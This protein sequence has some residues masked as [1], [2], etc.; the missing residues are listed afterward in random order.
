MKPLFKSLLLVA[1]MAFSAVP[2]CAD[3][4]L[5]AQDWRTPGDAALTQD[6]GTGLLWLDLSGPGMPFGMSV[7]QVLPELGAGGDFA[8]FRYATEAE[9]LTL[10][11]HAGLADLSGAWA[12]ANYPPVLDLQALVG[13]TRASF[14]ET[15][16]A[17]ATQGL[18]ASYVLGVAVQQQSNPLSAVYQQA[19]VLVVNDVSLDRTAFLGHW[20][21]TPV[22]E[23][24]T[25]TLLA[26]G[27]ALLALAMGRRLRAG[28]GAPARREA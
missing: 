9:V 11:A 20:L 23:P 27:L 18:N 26:A 8:G 2:A 13:V 6:T 14:G 17:T 4:A 12:S 22:P 24:A 3:A 21:V 19:R 10:L 25:A 1:G 7:A 15:F 16:G 28:V 5:V